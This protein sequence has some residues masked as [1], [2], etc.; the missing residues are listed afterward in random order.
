MTKEK[1]QEQQEQEQEQE[2]QEQEQ[3]E[4]QEQQETL[5]KW[6]QEVSQEK[7]QYL[8]DSGMYNSAI[9]GYVMLAAEE[10]SFSKEQ[11]NALLGGIMKA[12]N[13]YD[14]AAAENKYLSR[15]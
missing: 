1:Q 13:N 3:Q 12:L 10:A 11:I 15:S 5:T 7:L 14:K 8:L 6:A 9:K 4:Q 2:Q